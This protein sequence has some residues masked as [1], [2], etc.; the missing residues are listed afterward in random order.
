MSPPLSW[1]D[2]GYRPRSNYDLNRILRDDIEQMAAVNDMVALV[3]K[4][5]GVLSFTLE[6]LK[7]MVGEVRECFGDAALEEPKK[8]E[9]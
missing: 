7:H 9:T 5:S 4:K 3:E 1:E 2:P 8:C 6:D